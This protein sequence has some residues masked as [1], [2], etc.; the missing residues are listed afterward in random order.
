MF[1]AVIPNIAVIMVFSLALIW[2]FF[3]LG[4]FS[5]YILWYWQRG[6]HI[7]GD[8]RVHI[9]YTMISDRRFRNYCFFKNI[10]IHGSVHRNSI[11][12]RSNKM[13]QYAGI[14][15]LQNHPACFG[16]PSHT[17]SGAHKTVTAASGT[18]TTFLQRRTATLEKRCCCTRGCSYSF[19]W[20]WW[21]VRWT[22][23]TR[24]VIL[25]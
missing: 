6:N 15:L 14:Y 24:R 25:Q 21:C 11:L 19:M 12:I 10:Y 7:L 4:S 23:E 2:V 20:S 1:Q 5:Y 18:A 13:Q 8:V 3:F 22:P 17:S 16:C 9:L